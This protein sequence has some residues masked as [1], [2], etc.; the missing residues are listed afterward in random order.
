MR[1]GDR[2]DVK[3]DVVMPTWNSN[4][5]YFRQIV[6]RVRR[7][8]ELNRLI[9]VDRF[10]TDGTI[11][12]VKSVIEPGKLLIVQ[13]DRELACARALGIK[14]VTTPVFMFIDSDVL[15]PR[16]W[17]VA[18]RFLLRRRNV[19]AVSLP[20]CGPRRGRVRVPRL[21]RAI[22]KGE[23]VKRG[24]FQL[25]K[26]DLFLAVML[27]EL[28][29]DWRP[30]KH[31]S[32]G[33]VFSLTQHILEKGYLWVELPSPCC[34]HT[35]ELKMGAGPSR[36]FKQGLWEGAGARLLG[37]KTSDFVLEVTCRLIGGVIRSTNYGPLHLINNAAMRLGQMIGFLSPFRYRT[38]RRS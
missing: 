9:V 30:L 29:R 6:E 4:S 31:L 10:S 17:E 28:V 37:I 13:T 26:G 20:L 32:A 27:T 5:P 1:G 7:F 11:E 3:I 36:Y 12:T 24:L 35:K 14:Q 21:Y 38:W 16:G 8:V 15:M 23:I 2:V 22:H 33:E 19:G 34:H 18:L 25:T